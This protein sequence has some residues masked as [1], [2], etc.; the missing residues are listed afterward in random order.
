MFC[1]VFDIV[2]DLFCDVV[3]IVV[4]LFYD[5]VDI[6]VDLFCDVVDI[7][8]GLLV[9]FA[10]ISFYAAA[11]LMSTERTEHLKLFLASLAR[12]WLQRRV[13]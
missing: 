3:D 8:V 2:V 1:D 12:V 13:F 9:R 6:V 4:D 11:L 10:L 7:V 5:V